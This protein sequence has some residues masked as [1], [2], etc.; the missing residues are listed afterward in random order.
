MW[1]RFAIAGLPRMPW[2][3]GGGSTREV[4]CHPPGA[5]MDTFDWRV[6]IATIAQSGPFSVFA[7]VDRSIMLLEG[8]GVQLH[9]PGRFD[10]RLVTAG[11][12]FAFAGDEAVACTL[13]GGESTDFNV[14]TR[15]GVVQAQVQVHHADAWHGSASGGVLLA[16]DGSWTL[17]VDGS[18]PQALQAGEGLWWADGPRRWRLQAQSSQARLVSVGIAPQQR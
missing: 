4:V 16:V 11:Q 12:P 15:R 8:D 6:S 17:H 2:K 13:L 18:V 9:A 3:N 7:G 10:H 14:M 5:D 1:T